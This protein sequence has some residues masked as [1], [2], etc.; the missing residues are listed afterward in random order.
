MKLLHIWSEEICVTITAAQWGVRNW[1]HLWGRTGQIVA[2]GV[3]G[4]YG[5]TTNEE[6]KTENVE[7][8]IINDGKEI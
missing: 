5:F 4:Y 3:M 8:L 2:I 1:W 7:S 6:L